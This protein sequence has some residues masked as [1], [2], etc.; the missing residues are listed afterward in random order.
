MLLPG[1]KNIEKYLGGRA[2]G[3]Y[4]QAIRKFHEY[5]DAGK[6]VPI[7]SG[8]NILWFLKDFDT[9]KN[10]AGQYQRGKRAGQYKSKALV[11]IGR[12]S[13][14]LK[15]HFDFVGMWETRKPVAMKH[16]VRLINEAVRGMN[17]GKIPVV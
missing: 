17:M 14:K 9:Y 8:G 7:K 1:R 4:M 13:V 16:G 2:G 12:K 6:L 10:S 15:P 3:E 5:A 11:F